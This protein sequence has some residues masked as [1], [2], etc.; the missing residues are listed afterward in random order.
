M[1][2]KKIRKFSNLIVAT[3]VILN[4]F[5]AFG[6][7]LVFLRVGSEPTTLIVSWFAFTT[8][9]L[10]LMKDIKK[11]KIKKEELL[12]GEDKLETEAFQ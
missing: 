12:N 7:L 10:W 1:S 3:V 2:N 9:E 11:A 4:S 5:F 6:V 8:G